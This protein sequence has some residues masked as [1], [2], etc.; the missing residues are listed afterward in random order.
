MVRQPLT[1]TQRRIQTLRTDL[2]AQHRGM[3]RAE[4]ADAHQAAA[5][6]QAQLAQAP[7][8]DAEF[9]AGALASAEHERARAAE[10][11]DGLR[12]MEGMT[13]ANRA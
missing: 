8:A 11:R 2:D 7:W 13:R 1:G 9:R 5:E 6:S 4:I 3:S 10:I 12:E